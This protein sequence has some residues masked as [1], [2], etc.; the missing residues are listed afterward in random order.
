M[1]KVYESKRPE[2]ITMEYLRTVEDSIG[3]LEDFYRKKGR[4]LLESELDCECREHYPGSTYDPRLDACVNP[5]MDN[6]VL[7]RE[8]REIALTVNTNSQ[9]DPNFRGTWGTPI[10]AD[11]SL[12]ALANRT[13]SD[14]NS[15]T[16]TG[17]NPADS[18]GW[19]SGYGVAS[20]PSRGNLESM[21]TPKKVV[22]IKV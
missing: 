16:L 14:Q 11:V 19:N 7:R 3:H 17:T 4:A 2:I 6:S 15:Q 9:T 20:R 21:N 1:V 13:D 22:K 18:Y 5:K 10:T 8:G 12:H